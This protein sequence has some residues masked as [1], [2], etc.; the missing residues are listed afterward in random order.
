M[1]HVHVRKPIALLVC[2]CFVATI[3]LSSWFIVSHVH[4]DCSGHDCS[5]CVQI[6]YYAELF[7]KLGRSLYS[8]TATA[9]VLALFSLSPLLAAEFFDC[10][11]N[12]P[13]GLKV[14][15]NN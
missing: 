15:L 9:L 2:I 1:I 14:R 3:L 4:H 8:F 10:Q 11:Q 5:V 12:T 7:Q 6:H 13:V